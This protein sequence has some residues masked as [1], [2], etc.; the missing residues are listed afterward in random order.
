MDGGLYLPQGSISLA[1]LPL[2]ST[3]NNSCALWASPDSTSPPPKS[4]S[5]YPLFHFW[6]GTQNNSQ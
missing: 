2:F 4:V 3:T 5:I 6:V 1:S